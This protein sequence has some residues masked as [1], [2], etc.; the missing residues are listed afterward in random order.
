MATSE[1]LND[2]QEAR[3]NLS[4]HDVD[5]VAQGEVSGALWE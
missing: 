3:K 2:K 5:S 4:L 1:G